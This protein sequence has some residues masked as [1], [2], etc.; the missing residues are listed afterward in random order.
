MWP[1]RVSNPGPLTCESGVLPMRYEARLRKYVPPGSVFS[2]GG[3]LI[4][5]CYFRFF[6][7]FLVSRD[8]FLC[9]RLSPVSHIFTTKS[10]IY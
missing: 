8:L 9:V 6:G 2:G 5:V 3:L 4:T 7:V 10:N 1:D